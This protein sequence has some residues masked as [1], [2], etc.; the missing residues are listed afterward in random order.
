[1]LIPTLVK[2]FSLSAVASASSTSPDRLKSSCT[3]PPVRKEWQTLSAEDQAE[4]ID[5]VHCLATKPSLVA[6]LNT[7]LFDD[8]PRIHYAMDRQS[9]EALQR[10]W[11]VLIYVLVHFVASFLPWHRWFVHV[12]ESALKDC[13]Y[14][15]VAT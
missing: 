8:F 9:E 4:Y 6:S 13:G 3:N 12:Y 15:G 7:T 2:I 14:K 1:M 5:A 11:H 10:G